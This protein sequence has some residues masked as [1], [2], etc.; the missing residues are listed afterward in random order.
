MYIFSSDEFLSPALGFLNN[1]RMCPRVVF[2]GANS[3][4]LSHRDVSSPGLIWKASISC[5]P[6]RILL[7]PSL[8]LVR[9]IS[10]FLRG[11][12]PRKPKSF[13]WFFFA[14]SPIFH[15]LFQVNGLQAWMQYSSQLWP[16]Q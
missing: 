4:K 1:V 6:T 16:K 15:V 13:L 7:F 3:K 9:N 10:S 5:S 12:N 2:F 8:Y 14:L 11:S